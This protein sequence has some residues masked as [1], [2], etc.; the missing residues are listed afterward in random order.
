MGYSFFFLFLLACPLLMFFMMRS[1]HAG[2]G[3]GADDEAPHRDKQPF[4]AEVSPDERINDLERKF[5]EMRAGAD[6]ID[7][8]ARR[9]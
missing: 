4:R 6:R 3:M 1:M 5:A 9:R 8:D 7:G 2:H